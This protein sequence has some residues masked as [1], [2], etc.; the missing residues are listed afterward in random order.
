MP[1]LE[2]FRPYPIISL[3]RFGR[4]DDVL[5]EPKPDEALRITTAIWHF[6]RGN[7]YV[8]TNQLTNARDEVDALEAVIKTIPADAPLGNNTAA[9]ILKIADLMLNGK[10]AFASGD[11]QAGIA[12]LNEAAAG[13]D[14]MSYNEPADWDLPVREVLGSVLLVNGDYAA[15]EKV[16]RDEL[17]RHQKNGRAFFGLAESL[18]KQ[19]KKSAAE[20]ASRDFAL[21]WKDADTKLTVEGLSGLPLK[22]SASNAAPI[23][24]SSVALKTGVRLRYAYQGDANGTP[25]AFMDAM[26]IKQATIVGHSMGSF[27]AQNVAAKAPERFAADLQAFIN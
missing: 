7:A 22:K 2:M 1:M 25:V 8:A 9:H 19:G 26:K 27:V 21:A 24:F 3:V 5:K 23:R 6:A 15:A 13:E 12:L 10:F 16:F 11:K 14:A 18:K 20:A 17:K 4:W